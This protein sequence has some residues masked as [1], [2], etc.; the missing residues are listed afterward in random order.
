MA[1]AASTFEWIQCSRRVKAVIGLFAEHTLYYEYP[2]NDLLRACI[3]VGSEP[4]VGNEAS[5]IPSARRV[6]GIS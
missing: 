3:S 5:D 4:G 2:Q 1:E 6:A